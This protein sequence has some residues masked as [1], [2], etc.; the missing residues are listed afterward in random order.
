MN[1]GADTSIATGRLMFTVIGAVACF[2]RELMLE[3]Q[4]EGIAKAKAEGKIQ[5]T[6]T[7][8]TGPGC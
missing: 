3:R 4:R 5:G 7:H 2:E 6:E 8:S 1:L